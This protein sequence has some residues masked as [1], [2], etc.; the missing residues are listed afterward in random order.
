MARL[1]QEA[2]DDGRS[3]QDMIIRIVELYFSRKAK[4]AKT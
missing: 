1:L 4:G 2:K 3:R